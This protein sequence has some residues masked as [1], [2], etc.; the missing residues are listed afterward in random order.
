MYVENMYQKGPF[1]MPLQLPHSCKNMTIR[2]SITLL[3]CVA[4][5]I[6]PSLEWLID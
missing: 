2:I 6:K 3:V 1:L 5:W 4:K